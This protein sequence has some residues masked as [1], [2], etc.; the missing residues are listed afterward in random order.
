VPLLP[1]VP[2]VAPGGAASPSAT[3]AV[4]DH[5]RE[6]A[7]GMVAEG[8]RHA[9][10]RAW[11]LAIL[12]F[13]DAAERDPS[14]AEAH[15]KLGVAYANTKQY[16]LAVEHWR[17]VL[18]LRPGDVGATEN[19]RR[20]EERLSRQPGTRSA[21]EV[22][23][24]AEAL[25]A[26]GDFE[27]ARAEADALLRMQ[28]DYA[29]GH[30][31]RGD[32]LRGLRRHAEAIAAYNRALGLAPA[33]PD[34]HFGLAEAYAASGSAAAARPHYEAYLKGHGAD[35]WKAARARARLAEPVP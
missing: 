12:S 2:A 23:R 15:F 18:E 24:R 1:L 21:V 27:A 6:V 8:D 26:R 9:A 10:E 19:I 31:T 13:R 11:S 20:A 29:P 33:L 14:N 34:A 3:P 35:P 25:M 30:V 16:A 7:R 22:L 32:A 17:R 28:A 5:D 4:P